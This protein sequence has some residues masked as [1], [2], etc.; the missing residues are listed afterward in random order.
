MGGQGD[1]P[2]S[3]DFGV[4]LTGIDSVIPGW[5]AINPL[6]GT[7]FVRHYPRW[8][9]ILLYGQALKKFTLSAVSVCWRH[10]CQKRGCQKCR[11]NLSA[12]TALS[13]RFGIILSRKLMTRLYNILLVNILFVHNSAAASHCCE[14]CTADKQIDLTDCTKCYWTILCWTCK[15][16]KSMA[17]PKSRTVGQV[18]QHS[19]PSDKVNPKTVDPVSNMYRV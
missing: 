5:D 7:N 4:P 16:I 17:A 8:Q 13:D 1:M 18:G 3:L 11:V 2:S 10:G 6:T 14:W 12:E 9:Q 19:R 15:W